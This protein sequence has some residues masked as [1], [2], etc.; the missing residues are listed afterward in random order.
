MTART[1]IT[2]SAEAVTNWLDAGRNNQAA[3]RM[4]ATNLYMGSVGVAAME[5]GAPLFCE[6]PPVEQAAWSAKALTAMG[7]RPHD[8]EA[9]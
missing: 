1:Y 8:L 7:G 2:P 6:L 5:A 3:L 4:V 9:R